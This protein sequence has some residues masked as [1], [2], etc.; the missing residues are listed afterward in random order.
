[1]NVVLNVLRTLNLKFVEVEIRR[2][3][4]HMTKKICEIALVLTVPVFTYAVCSY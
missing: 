4:P 1:M 3:L 2:H